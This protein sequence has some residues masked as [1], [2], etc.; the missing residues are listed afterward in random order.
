MKWSAN[1]RWDMD[2]FDEFEFKPLTN[3]LGFHKKTVSLKDGLK[4][5]GVLDDE[6]HGVPAS[7]PQSLLDDAPTS[8]IQPKRHTFEDV[9]SALEKK[10][11]KKL[12]PTLDLD[13]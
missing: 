11:A 10:P 7:V 12:M 5:S 3:G 6:L 13:F 8:A 1:P 4:N 2:P 9:L